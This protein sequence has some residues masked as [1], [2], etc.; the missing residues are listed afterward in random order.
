M[1]QKCLKVPW[2]FVTWLI[3]YSGLVSTNVVYFSVHLQVWLQR[4]YRLHILRAGFLAAAWRSWSARLVVVR[5]EPRT[6]LPS[7]PDTV[8]PRAAV[9]T[10]WADA[11]RWSRC[12]PSIALHTAVAA[13]CQRVNTTSSSVRIVLVDV[14]I[15]CGA[16]NT[17]AVIGGVRVV[18]CVFTVLT[19]AFDCRWRVIMDWLPT[20]R[21]GWLLF[22][23]TWKCRGIGQPSGLNFVTENCLLQVYGYVCVNWA[24]LALCCHFKRTFSCVILEHFAVTFI[25]Y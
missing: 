2:H 1:T 14:W 6:R 19:V 3:P 23:K 25:V 13:T 4:H 9:G 12:R 21:P 24:F 10:V 15:C 8:G 22:W 16:G 11:A 17:A 7:P 5:G 18:S 20:C